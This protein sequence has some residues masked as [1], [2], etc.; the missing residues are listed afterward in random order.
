MRLQS[1]SLPNMFSILWRLRYRT[2]S[3]CIWIFLFYF[4]G[5]HASVGQ[6]VTQ[7]VAVIT[8]CCACWN[9]LAANH[10]A[11]S[12]DEDVTAAIF[13]NQFLFHEIPFASIA[14]EALATIN[15]KGHRSLC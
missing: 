13:K 5:M 1:F 9:C 15:R 8:L 6:G 11:L 14:S 4:D 12:C 3:W 10:N 7:P 2:R